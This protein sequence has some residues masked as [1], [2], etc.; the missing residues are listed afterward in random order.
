M[1]APSPAA[2]EGPRTEV[3]DASGYFVAPGLIDSH[4]HYHHTYLDPAEA[5]K[6]LLR[7]GVTGTADGFYGEAIVGG[8][9]AVR[10]I[11]DGLAR[12]PI[13]LIF[14][15]PTNPAHLPRAEPSLP[16]EPHVRVEAG[17]GSERRRPQG[18][19]GLAGLLRP[20]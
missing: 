13:R 19:A 4:L 18:D 3:I 6:L 17:G 11:K 10:A 12:V 20:R 16:S 7:R 1:S 2:A 15:A 8:I 9:E 14:L 5:A